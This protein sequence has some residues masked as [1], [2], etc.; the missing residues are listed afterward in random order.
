MEATNNACWS[1]CVFSQFPV[2]LQSR[3]TLVGCTFESIRLRA[4]ISGPLFLCFTITNPP[5]PQPAPV[6]FFGFLFFL[7]PFFARGGVFSRVHFLGIE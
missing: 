4:D 6:S 2:S 5:F 7:L 3:E 1:F